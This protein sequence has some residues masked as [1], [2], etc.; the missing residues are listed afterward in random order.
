MLMVVGIVVVVFY[1]MVNSCFLILIQIQIYKFVQIL[2]QVKC[3]FIWQKWVCSCDS[4]DL[5][6]FLD[7][8]EFFFVDVCNL[9]LEQEEVVE[10]E[11]VVRYDL[12]QVIFGDREVMVDGGQD[13]DYVLIGYDL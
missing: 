1:F 10:G 4:C 6:R 9:I 2:E 13:N 12:L 7:E 3:N 5:Y 11:G 8:D